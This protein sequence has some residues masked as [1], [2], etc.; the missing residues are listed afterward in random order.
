MPSVIKTKLASPMLKRSFKNKRMTI[1][2][3]KKI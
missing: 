2:Q 1:F 3:P